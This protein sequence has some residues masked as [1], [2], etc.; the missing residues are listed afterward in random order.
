MGVDPATGI[1]ILEDV[2]GKPTFDPKYPD[3]YKVIIN[4][5]QK[6]DGGFQNN[7]SYKNIQLDLSF[8]FVKQ[9]GSNLAYISG[10]TA[11]GQFSRY[12]GEINQL[13]CYP[14]GKNPV[15]LLVFNDFLPMVWS[16]RI[17]IMR[18]VVME[19]LRMLPLS[20]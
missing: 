16:I 7:I 3:D 10:G 11:P 5:F 14:G 19:L 13:Q 17:Y 2:N 18:K 12:T 6:F 9:T 8:Q 4:P 15:I 1:Y 20:A